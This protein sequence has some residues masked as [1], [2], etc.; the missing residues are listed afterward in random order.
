MSVAT[1][2]IALNTDGDC[3]VRDITREVESELRR[4]EMKN[5]IV[6]VFVPG[7]TG[8]VTT[9]EFEEGLVR[10]LRELFDSVAP[11]GKTYHHDQKWH[12]GN[13]HSHVRASLLG[14][15]LTVPF[16]DGELILGTWQQIVFIDFDVRR[17]SRKLVLQ[18]LGE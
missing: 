1:R 13:G 11:R 6:T 15:S 9:V 5:G 7:A 4:T 10:D 12:D 18:F 16:S 3:D 2:F 14:P 17:R 8:G